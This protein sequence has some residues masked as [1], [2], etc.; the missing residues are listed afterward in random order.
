M[1]KK[2]PTFKAFIT[3]VF[4]AVGLPVPAAL[5]PPTIETAKQS[6]ARPTDMSI[7]SSI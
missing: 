4:V 7:I 1:P 2:K 6:I 5:A 3:F